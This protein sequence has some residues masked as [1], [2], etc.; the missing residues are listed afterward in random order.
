MTPPG[1]M[2]SRP[3]GFS[4]LRVARFP[5]SFFPTGNLFCKVGFIT[6]RSKTGGW[7]Q[8][9]G[10]LEIS[11]RQASAESGPKGRWKILI[12]E[13]VGKWTLKKGNHF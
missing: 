11:G 10:G 9:R 12:L 13:K 6:K 7:L 1:R 2:A 3:D 4:R 5:G 8:R